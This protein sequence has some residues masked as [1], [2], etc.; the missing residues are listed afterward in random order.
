MTNNFM[1]LNERQHPK[2]WLYEWES[3]TGLGV[4]IKYK[5]RLDQKKTEYQSIEV[6]ETEHFKNLLV[7]DQCV[8]ISECFGYIYSEAIAHT[9]TFLHP[10]PKVVWLIG[11]GDCGVLGELLK[12]KSLEKITMIELDKQV[13]FIS[14]KYLKALRL[15]F[16]G[17]L[18]K[19]KPKDLR[20][21]IIIDE[22]SEWMKE[23]AEIGNKADIIIV[24]CNDPTAEPSAKVFTKEFYKNC[25]H[26]LNENGLLIGQSESPLIHLRTIDEMRSRIKSCGF[27]EVRTFSFPIPIYPSGT[28]SATI[29]SKGEMPSFRENDAKNKDFETRYYN[30]EIHKASFAM[31]EFFK[32]HMKQS[33]F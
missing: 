26:C 7:I 18:E 21:S 33:G 24:D 28:W 16:E 19:L 4:S 6:F 22:G 13:I 2:K 9:I 8:M 14:H 15:E 11:G 12:H 30:S 31:P 3:N 25:H 17:E 32:N 20:A 5:K 23:Q 29:A 10:N 27:N 1:I